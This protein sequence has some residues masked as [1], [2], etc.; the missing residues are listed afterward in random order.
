M[1]RPQTIHEASLGRSSRPST[2]SGPPSR[3]STYASA[4]RSR[5]HSYRNTPGGN[6]PEIGEQG[7]A[8]DGD[9][10]RT[11][12]RHTGDFSAIPPSSHDDVHEDWEEGHESPEGHD[13]GNGSGG[14]GQESDGEARRLRDVQEAINVS[15]PFGLR[16]WKP[17]LYRKFRSIDTKTYN[18]LH[19]TPGERPTRTLYLNPGNILWL[20]LFGWWLALVYFLVATVVL[21]PLAF[22]G[23][24]GATIY[25]CGNEREEIECGL[26]SCVGWF[27]IELENIW[28]YSK[29]LMNLSGYILWPFGKFIAKRRVYHMVFQEDHDGTANGVSNERTAL[30]SDHDGQRYS[31]DTYVVGIPDDS[32][33]ATPVPEPASS[34]DRQDLKVAACCD[35]EANAENMSEV[36]EESW[37]EFMSSSRRYSYANGHHHRWPKW[38]PRWIRRAYNAGLAGNLFRLLLLITI[39]PLQFVVACMCSFLVF[40]LPMA[41]LNYVLLK[42]LFRHPLQISAHTPVY[43]KRPSTRPSR[44]ASLAS[45]ASDIWRRSSRMF[46]RPTSIFSESA[47]PIAIP[48]TLGTPT[49]MPSGAVAQGPQLAPEFQVIL[50]TYNAL[51]WDYYKYTYDGINIIVINLIAVVIFALVDFYVIGPRFGY[52][53]IASNTV[54][55]VASLISSIPLAYFIGMAVASITSETGSLAVGAVINATFGSIIEIILYSL[56]LV[57]GKQRMVEGAIVGSLLAGLLAL[58]GVSMFFGGLK[59]KEQRFNAK[60]AGVTATM[61]IVAVVGMFTPTLFQEVYGTQK[62]KC[63]ECPTTVDQHSM[64]PLGLALSCK[65]C[66]LISPRPSED[67][68][69]LTSTRPLAWLCA[70]ALLL[71]YAVGLLFT[72][73]THSRVI[74]DKPDKKVKRRRRAA[75]VSRALDLAKSDH[76]HGIRAIGGLGITNDYGA[77]AADRELR[78]SRNP[79]TSAAG[80]IG[81]GHGKRVSRVS[82][83]ASIPPNEYPFP[84]VPLTIETST[85]SRPV[86]LTTPTTPISPSLPPCRGIQTTSGVVQVVHPDP[87][88]SVI[89]GDDWDTASTGSS[90]SDESEAHG[91]DHPN[92]SIFKSALVLLG[93]TTL[94]SLVAEV[95]I[96]SV[97]EVI[98]AY[99]IDEKVLGATLFSIV[100]LV[101]EFYNA[102]AFAMNGNIALSLEIGS[103]YVMQAAM[104]QIPVMVA[105]SSLFF[106]PSPADPPS[107]P[108]SPLTKLYALFSTP[109]TPSTST[110]IDGFT[111]IFPRW[112]LYAVLFGTFMLT[113]VYTE[114]K[115]NYFKGSMLL[116]AYFILLA[117]Y[118]FEPGD[119]GWGEAV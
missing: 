98:E 16:I 15:H 50:C 18:A 90:E 102:I 86:S 70:A 41:K 114:G 42:H 25:F 66:R 11:Q 103:A 104:L 3:H 113:Y 9:P 47:E 97:D 6:T 19:A 65:H 2:P 46:G 74:Y 24:V 118:V 92:W 23:K 60:A 106:K 96:S 62:L 30:L 72:L 56:A 61:L 27:F 87:V 59:K 93:C 82:N 4:L 31:E 21:G 99:D 1:P 54:I 53:G 68:I 91:H 77:E 119:S 5:T 28:Q 79:R 32:V 83:A 7:E 10:D 89:G 14:E 95:L 110:S 81:Q 71:M 75:A 67:P 111:M 38:V 43:S 17:A 44:S 49:Q 35:N 109:T 8:W 100:P 52:T 108:T 84:N 20:I 48:T 40:P 37:H 64:T 105:F 29:V 69:Y 117:G 57:E 115:S 76:H 107:L 80:N 78:E 112:D 45:R 55:F 22:L 58:P 94:Y 39:A 13:S 51:G 88:V 34:A 85:G 33:P 73:R 101:T 36:S 116:V 12:F 26:T 63:L